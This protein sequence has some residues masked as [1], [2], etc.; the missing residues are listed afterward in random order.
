MRS[1]VSGLT[2]STVSRLQLIGFS[3]KKM[4]DFDTTS[5]E[6][7]EPG[8]GFFPSTCWSR[9]LGGGAGPDP[10]SRRQ[11]LEELATRYWRPVYIYICGR[12]SRSADDAGDLTQDFFVWMLESDLLARA[13]PGRGRFRG[14]IK[15]ALGRFLI[16]GERREL[17]IKRG[18]DRIRVPLGD[19]DTMPELAD[20]RG[21]S[22]E[23]LLDES[24]RREVLAT[25]LQRLEDVL[26]REDKPV[27]FDVFRDYYL[28]E[29]EDLDY[30]T[31][32]ARYQITR[33]DVSNHLMH[34]KRRYQSCLKAVVQETVG[35]PG[36]LREELEWLFGRRG[37]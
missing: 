18:G 33:S 31:V 25:A 20:S 24:W 36:E 34:A 6:T 2:L 17:R 15:V 8:E 21:K 3:S 7:P 32:A 12:R 27:V 1:R 35:G 28:S 10:R 11:D 22:P 26:G 5:F 29:A 37:S 4:G 23:E 30:E 19:G 14:L 9:I 16:D 13:D